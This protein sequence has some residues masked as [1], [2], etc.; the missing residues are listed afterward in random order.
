[1]K[2]SIYWHLLAFLI[3]ILFSCSRELQPTEATSTYYPISD[4]LTIDSSVVQYIQP[5]KDSLKSEM[6]E[7]LAFSAAEMPKGKPESL[8]GNLIADLVLEK[9]REHYDGP[10]DC[11]VM[12]YGGLRIPSLP[13]GNITKGKIFEL[14]PFDNFLVIMELKG[15][16]LHRLLDQIA[17]NGGWPIAG[18]RFVIKNNKATNIKIEGIPINDETL[19]H[20]AIS[21]YLADGGDDLIF[22]RQE[23]R[24]NLGIFLRDVMIEYFREHGENGMVVT[25]QLDHRITYN[26]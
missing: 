3:L 19:Y 2:R 18:I 16:V 26:E 23:K 4:T 22:L 8:M 13:E 14:M 10:V 11:S 12:N 25:S 1:M 24:E 15:T 6:N 20:V 7:V 5:F 9:S 21:D 17:A